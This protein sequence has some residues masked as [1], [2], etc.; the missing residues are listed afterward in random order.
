MTEPHAPHTGLDAPRPTLW[1]VVGGLLAV[2]ALALLW[3]MQFVGQV[4]TM[5]YP[6]PP[7]CGAPQPQVAAFVGMGL[8]IA[9]FAAQVVL[10]A[11]AVRPRI[12]IIVLSAGIIAVVAIAAAV[13][14]LSQTGI[15]DP[16]QPLVIVD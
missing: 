4:C 14:A 15:W 11:T 6:A 9:L 7:G 12:P 5:I 16:Y 13:V 3:P 2:V 8:V 10:F 1:L